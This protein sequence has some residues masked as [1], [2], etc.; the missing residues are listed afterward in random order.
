M[1]SAPF[2]VIVA[3]VAACHGGPDANHGGAGGHAPNG[4]CA[5]SSVVTTTSCTKR[6]IPASNA[7]SKRGCKSDADCKDGV[8][9][10]CVKNGDYVEGRLVRS[11]LLAGPPAMPPPTICVYDQCS[12][13]TECGPKARCWCGEGSG[14]NRCVQLDACLADADCGPHRLCEC[15]AGGSPNQ[16]MSGD[17]RSDADCGGD[18]GSCLHGEAGRFC[19]TA[20]DGCRTQEDC[21]GKS[22]EYETCDFDGSTASWQCRVV[23]PRPAG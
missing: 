16:C 15:G 18:A 8:D 17:C 21:R 10:R 2:I 22:A 20:G 11:P 13:N 5:A 1:R 14:R 23:A 3:A 6:A 4:T 12:T 19:A 9:G 7:S